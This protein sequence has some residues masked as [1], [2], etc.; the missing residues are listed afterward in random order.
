MSEAAISPDRIAAAEELLGV[1]YTDTER[2]MMTKSI[3]A[4]VQ[5]ARKRI[6]VC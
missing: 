3:A 6:C 1:R 2:A 5:L 4:Q